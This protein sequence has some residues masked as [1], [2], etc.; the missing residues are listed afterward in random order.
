MRSLFALGFAGLALTGCAALPA[1]PVREDA[2]EERPYSK[3]PALPVTSPKEIDWRTPDPQTILVIDT[4]RGQVVVELVP[5]V[6]PEHVA[7]IVALTRKGIYDKRTFFRVID[8]FMAQTGDPL[9]TGEGQTDLPNLKAEFNFRRDQTTP[10]TP[11]SAPQGLEEGLIAS[12]P[13]VSQDISYRTMTSD[14][15]VA[16][17]GTYC[18][19]VVGMAR[20]EN[21]DSAN[22][23][24][25]LMRQ[26]YP[27]LDKRYTAFGRVVSGLESVRAIKAGEPVAAPQDMMTQVRVLADIPAAERPN[28]RLIDTGGSWFRAHLAAVRNN[29]GAD[30]SVCDLDLPA[31]ID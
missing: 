26:A 16:A 5:Q 9:N 1:Y 11:V 6:A 18:P 24:F 10:F 29:K 4:N 7:R 30:F 23:Q 22:S 25:F 21:P 15:K 8:R 12:L 13:I 31:R 27:S 3:P 2:A 28:V 19:G 14:G 20:D 17:W